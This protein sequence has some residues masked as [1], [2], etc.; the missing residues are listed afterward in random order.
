MAG[1][2]TE[3]AGD[4]HSAETADTAID[5]L[6]VHQRGCR[7]GNARVHVP[8]VCSHLEDSVAHTLVL[9]VMAASRCSEEGLECSA[10]Q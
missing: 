4:D 9:Q 2:K 8:V 6:P 5:S 10:R 3:A 1:T 7:G